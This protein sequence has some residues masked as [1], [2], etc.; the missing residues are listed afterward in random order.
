M[1]LL[2]IILEVVRSILAIW[3]IQLGWN[4][5]IVGGDISSFHMSFLSALYV[6]FFISLIV[7][8]TYTQSVINDITK[9]YESQILKHKIV[10]VV[11]TLLVVLLMW[12]VQMII[13]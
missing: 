11:G 3:C 2:G 13:F 6:Y 4:W 12:I 1:K 9:E 5:F 10:S 7:G 8:V